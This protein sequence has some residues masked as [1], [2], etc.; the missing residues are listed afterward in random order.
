MAR[1]SA[2]IVRK[3]RKQLGGCSTDAF[4]IL[5]RG[6]ERLLRGLDRLRAVAVTGAMEQ[7]L[8]RN[9]DHRRGDDLDVAWTNGPRG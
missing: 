7:P 9:A 8:L 2:L 4:E 1:L 6:G 3:F 5:D